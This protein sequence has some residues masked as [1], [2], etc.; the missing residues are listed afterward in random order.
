MQETGPWRCRNA[1]HALQPLIIEEFGKNVTDQ[2]LATI[3]KERNPTFQTV[4]G[5]LNRSLGADDVLKAAMVRGPDVGGQHCTVVRPS[6][7]PSKLARV[8]R[9]DHPGTLPHPF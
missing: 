5:A 1:C 6:L 9:A 8:W 3:Q 7:R 4:M 2:E